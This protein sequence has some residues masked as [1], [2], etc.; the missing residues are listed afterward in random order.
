M[1]IVA[2]YIEMSLFTKRNIILIIAAAIIACN[3]SILGQ[4]GAETGEGNDVFKVIVTLFGMTNS[5]KDVLTLVNVQDQTKIKLYNPDNPENAGLNKVS[6]TMTFPGIQVQDGEQYTVCT[7]TTENFEMHCDKGKNSP[8]N[9]PEFVDV[10][11]SGSSA[12]GEKKKD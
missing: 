8:L 7:M 2:L 5:T 11:L 9:R 12:K 4:T 1:N 6:Y 3:V 10:D